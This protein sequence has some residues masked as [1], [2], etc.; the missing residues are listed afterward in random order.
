MPFLLAG[1]SLLSM[2]VG[3]TRDVVRPASS[4]NN[5]CVRFRGTILAMAG[6]KLGDRG[7]GRTDYGEWVQYNNVYYDE[8]GGFDLSAF[9]RADVKKIGPQK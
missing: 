7:W 8:F 1:N 2:M 4:L 9:A 3:G 5:R 6:T